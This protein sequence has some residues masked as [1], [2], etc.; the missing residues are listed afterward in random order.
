MALSLAAQFLAFVKAVDGDSGEEDSYY[1]PFTHLFVDGGFKSVEQLAR[2]SLSDFEDVP[3][4][5]AGRSLVRRVLEQAKVAYPQPATAESQASQDTLRT[6]VQ[7]LQGAQAPPPVVQKVS[8]SV[9]A[10]LEEVTLEGMPSTLLPQQTATDELVDEG[11]K[12]RKRGV[13]HPFAFLDLRK[14]LPV[15]ALLATCSE[16]DNDE[17]SSHVATELAKALGL[18]LK[19]KAKPLTLSQWCAAYNCWANAAVAAGHY[20]LTPLPISCLDCCIIGC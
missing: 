9:G 14:F 17:P 16:V 10:K 6:V 8:L 20:F 11:E 1:T 13:V 4:K 12:Q 3:G 15:W 19:P 5:A 7:Q 18:P 2:A